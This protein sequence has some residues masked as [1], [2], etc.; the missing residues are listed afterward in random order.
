MNK[1]NGIYKFK[2]NQAII[3]FLRFFSNLS[4]RRERG[5]PAA[6]RAGG[7]FPPARHLRTRAHSPRA[8]P[9]A[10]GGKK[11]TCESAMTAARKWLKVEMRRAK[12]DFIFRFFLVL[13]VVFL[14]CFVFCLIYCFFFLM[15]WGFCVDGWICWLCWDIDFGDAIVCLFVSLTSSIYMMLIYN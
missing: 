13:Y 6:G 5:W 14:F 4:I 10:A 9:R 12:R 1:K 7:G 15:I 3:T 2:N 8:P 11:G